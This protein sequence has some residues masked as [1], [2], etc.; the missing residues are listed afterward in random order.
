VSTGMTNRRVTKIS[1]MP[2][3]P[4]GLILD[5]Y[6][7]S[8][9]WWK[10]T[11]YNVV[12]TDK[13]FASP[14][15]IIAD[16]SQ[17]PFADNTFDEVWADPP[18]WIRKS[19]LKRTYN[20]VGA[21]ATAWSRHALDRDHGYFGAYPTRDALRAEWLAVAKE[22]SRVTKPEAYL[23][24]KYIDGAKTVSQCCNSADTE[25]CLSPYWNLIDAV[26][27]PSCVSWST[28]ITVWSRWQ[29]K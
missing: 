4:H 23:T 29:R 9:C 8:R 5:P 10:G 20:F 3:Q 17:L 7:G 26:C 24:W 2:W 11:R 13:F 28:A 6:A 1:Q 12:F 25:T 19:P 27:Y 18:H 14:G 15:V 21:T 22:L 16:A